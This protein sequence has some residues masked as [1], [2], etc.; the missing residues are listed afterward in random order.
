VKIALVKL[1]SLGDVVHA[2]PVASTLKARLPHARL[3]WV[4][5]QREAAVLHGHP[6]LADVVTVDTRRWRR[7]RTGRDVAAAAREI[8]AVARRLGADHFDVA[9]DLQGL[10][11]SAVVAALTRAPLR[12]G[13]DVRRS[14][15]LS[16]L[17]TTRRV[18]PPA[19]ARHVVDQYLAL[20]SP[21]GVREPVLEFNLP[22]DADAESRMDAFFHR[23]GLKAGGRVV[24]LNP[25]AGRPD[26]R[27]PAE[28]FAALAS[29]IVDEAG[30]AVVIVWGPGEEPLARAIVGSL[31]G[32]PA[33]LAPRTGLVELVA[34]LR[35]VSVVVSGD[36]GPIHV[37]AALGTP[38]VGLYG[39]TSAER[40]GPY[41]RRHRTLA[42]PDGR[43]ESIG[44]EAA[45]R[46]VM[47]LLG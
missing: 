30:A 12:V 9:I 35:R 5:E 23:S 44:V 38:C 19:S 11:K 42:A 18:T 28:R 24:A 32:T 4:V 1:S 17:F 40:N 6:A 20:L 22:W 8:R 27:W 46:A 10:L 34:V 14:R 31:A 29:R 43:M 39:P 41:G 15:E 13:F 16:A 2:L 36:T 3:T 7:A 21:L 33:A 37:A 45:F 47:S 25:G 26:K